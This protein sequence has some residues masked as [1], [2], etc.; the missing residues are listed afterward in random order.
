MIIII[1]MLKMK[2]LMNLLTFSNNP[3]DDVE[4]S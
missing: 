1:I 3:T 2:C 4:I